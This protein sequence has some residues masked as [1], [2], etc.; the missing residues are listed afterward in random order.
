MVQTEQRHLCQFCDESYRTERAAR[1]CELN[2]RIENNVDRLANVRDVEKVDVYEDVIEWLRLSLDHVDPIFGT[3][4][5]PRCEYTVHETWMECPAC[6]VILRDHSLSGTL[7]C[8][9]CGNTDLTIG[10]KEGVTDGFGVQCS[11]C[12]SFVAHG[13]GVFDTRSHPDGEVMGEFHDAE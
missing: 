9:E 5:C 4:E 13:K 2:H 11:D 1:H 12:G 6:N 3:Q 7:S 10:R 8:A